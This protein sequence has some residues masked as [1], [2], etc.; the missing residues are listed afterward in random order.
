[1]AASHFLAFLASGRSWAWSQTFVAPI[2]E[3]TVGAHRQLSV[4]HATVGAQLA[5]SWLLP[6]EIA[7]AIRHH[8]DMGLIGTTEAPE[9]P[10]V[11]WTMIAIAQLAEHLMQLNT[12]SAQTNEWEKVAGIALEELG[13]NDR[14][15]ADL[16]EE[17]ATV[18][19]DDA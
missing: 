4:N 8:H 14:D 15:L 6:D 17:S 19:R 18:L 1:M 12:G 13:L 7:F 11:S 3:T 9:I 5:E 16:E 2:N 10:A